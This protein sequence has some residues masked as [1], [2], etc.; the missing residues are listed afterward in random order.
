MTLLSPAEMVFY[1][2]AKVYGY[3]V[4]ICV[5]CA[6]ILCDK[7]GERAVRCRTTFVLDAVK[8]I[9]WGT[10]VKK[11]HFLFLDNLDA[12][13]ERVERCESLTTTVPP[14]G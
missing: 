7:A 2:T 3:V 12:F 1:R 8:G 5:E 11:L 14:E 13:V 6:G 10:N 4:R 9:S